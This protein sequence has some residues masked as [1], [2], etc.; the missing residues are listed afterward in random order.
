MG[1]NGN[2]F[3]GINENGIEVSRVP[4]TG[5]GNEIMEMVGNG[6]LN[7]NPAHL[8]SVCTVSVN[9]N[10]FVIDLLYLMYSCSL[11]VSY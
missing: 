2:C 9:S 5:N 3:S 4:K 10:S 1:G 8:K 7:V 11:M 6:M